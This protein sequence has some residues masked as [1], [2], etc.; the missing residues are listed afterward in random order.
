MKKSG[1]SNRIKGSESTKPLIEKSASNRFSE[2]PVPVPNA[3]L[4]D[5]K[6]EA[7]RKLLSDHVETI[8]VLRNEKR[9]TFR[10]IADWLTARGI[11][12]D[13]SAVYRAYLG[14]IPIDQR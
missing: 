3:F 5:A 13:H 8:N 10:A 4:E 1:K 7:K 6:K 14:A 11:E 2:S 9:F 12:T